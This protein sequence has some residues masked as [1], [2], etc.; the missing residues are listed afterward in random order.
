MTSQERY[1]IHSQLEHLQAKYV[2]TG[3]ADTTKLCR[4][5]RPL[6]PHAAPRRRALVGARPLPHD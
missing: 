6:S 3:H 1:A 4:R 5:A 2:G